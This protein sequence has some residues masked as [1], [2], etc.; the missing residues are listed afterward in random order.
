MVAK[1]GE[2]RGRGDSGR[3]REEWTVVDP[4]VH[5][6][7]RVGQIGSFRPTIPRGPVFA[8]FHFVRIPQIK[9]LFNTPTE[10]SRCLLGVVV[11]FLLVLLKTA[12]GE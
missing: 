10:T 11:I 8:A 9:H 3:Y 1:I 2:F 12:R 4:I 7:V 5:F 6:V